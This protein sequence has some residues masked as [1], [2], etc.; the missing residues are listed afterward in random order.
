MGR[1]TLEKIIIITFDVV[2]F[3]TF[4]FFANLIHGL[5]VGII[6]FTIFSFV[7]CLIP[8]D[9]R[10]HADRLSHCFVLSISFLIYCV[11]IYQ[12]ALN[13]MNNIQSI[14]LSISLIILSN[15]TTTNCLWWKRNEL[16]ERVL[17]WTRF[18]LDNELLIKYKN[19]LKETD[20]RKYYIYVYYFEEHKSFETISQIMDIDRQRIGEEVAIMSHF[21][22]YGIR[23]R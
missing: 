8:D 19:N 17:E 20:K 11:L 5:F 23:L 14:I 7:N 12:F 13:Y 16:N 9:K 3:L 15:I 22:E 6:L 1:E 2:S 4:C 18:N 21:I 10:L